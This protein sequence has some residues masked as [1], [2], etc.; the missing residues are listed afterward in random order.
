MNKQTAVFY[1]FI[2]PRS[3]F[4]FMFRLI[5]T[6]T[7]C[8]LALVVVWVVYEVATFPRV[9]R[10]RTNN[11]ESTAMLNARMEEARG[12]G[13]QPRR[14]QSWVPLER[15]SPNL[16]R[17]VLA[18]EDVNFATHNGFDYQAIQKAWEQAQR[19]AA[20]EAKEEGE[21]DESSWIPQMPS[22]GR[23][24]STITQQLAKNLYLSTERSFLRKGR[25]AAITYFLERDLSKRRI[26]ELYLNVIEWGD[27]IY[28]AEAAAQNYFNKSAASLTT[29]E[30]AFLAAM[31][32]NPRTVF[33]PQKNPRRVRR[34]QRII[35]RGMPHVKLPSA[36]G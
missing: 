15:I 6:L 33:N 23:G 10:L 14:I 22:L 12:R 30:A 2:V 3:S 16:Q 27:G 9:S 31:I 11:P 7:L 5:K 19:D 25:E 21:G 34:R 32:P 4:V 8:V 26:L 20:R 36:T 1:T 18:G 28:G 24:A 29:Q 13:E 17:A 35:Q